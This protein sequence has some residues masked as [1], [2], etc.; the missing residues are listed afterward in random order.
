MRLIERH[1]KEIDTSDLNILLTA[2]GWGTRP[3][4]KWREILNKSKYVC[5]VWSGEQLVGFGRVLEDGTMAM[6]YDIAVHPE[7]QRRGVGSTVM[8]FLME[9]VRSGNYCSIGLFAWQENLNSIRFYEK[10][11]F[12]QVHFGMKLSL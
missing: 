4:E 3:E 11:G 7:F 12:Q 1:D 10:F 6:F 9:K 5:S 8:K 2:V